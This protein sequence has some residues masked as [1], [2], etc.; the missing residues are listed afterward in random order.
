MTPQLQSEPRFRPIRGQ[1]DHPR[2]FRKRRG[3][4]LIWFALLF[5]AL[6]GFVGLVIDVG[7]LMAGQ[8]QAQNAAD[9]GALAAAQDKLLK[10]NDGLAR[11]S[12]ITFVKNYNPEV[13]A[14]IPDPQ[15]NIP[16]LSGPYAGKS[17]Y[18]EV[19]V[20]FRMKTYL[21]HLIPGVNQQQT[22]K[23]RAVA[24]IE[25][26]NSGEGVA[27]LNPD[28]RPGI[29]VSGTSQL[30]VNGL[31]CSNSE[32]GGIDENGV[33]V[34]N[35][36][37]GTSITINQN[38]QITAV[39]VRTVGGVNSLTGFVNYEAGGSNPL[40]ANQLPISDPL[41]YLP[42]P[43]T[44]TGVDPTERGSP[45]STDGK[46]SANDPSGKNYVETVGDVSTLYLF[47][48]IYNSISISGGNVHFYPG[49]Y[50]LKPVTGGAKVL[51]VS[52]GSIVANGVMFYNTGSNYNP[53]T[54]APDIYDVNLSPPATDG[55]NFG[56]VSITSTVTFT[57]IDTTNTAY[58]YGGYDPGAPIPATDFNGM[59]LF[60]RPLNTQEFALAG[61]SS[62]SDF[63]GTMYSR[64]GNAKIT[65][66]G[67]FNVQFIVGSI[68]ISGQGSITLHSLGN[69]FSWSKQVFLVE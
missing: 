11:A 50:V 21:I 38:G 24:G 65:G 27:V 62:A 64:W 19:V 12:A 3:M 46:Q 31:V 32:G 61:N 7:I 60:Q 56:S 5:V 33:P 55:A 40:H 39:E 17:D 8:R 36:N 37:S 63:H 59:M 69:Y 53:S 54:G 34:T 45:T 67:S 44:A 68:D 13:L 25:A 51:T 20:A 58:H 16:P 1:T 23:A 30:I 6:I 66:Q 4:V 43:T 41:K 22:I 49:I 14:V 18:V 47:P 42:I 10:K 2:R 28:A 57:G 52:G 35:G 15:V 9:A 48:G 29:K 26:L